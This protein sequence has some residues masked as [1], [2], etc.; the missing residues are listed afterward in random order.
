MLDVADLVGAGRTTDRAFN[1]V[2][3]DATSN[4]TGALFEAK[5]GEISHP[6]P[7]LV[8]ASG[9]AHKEGSRPRDA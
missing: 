8:P 1:V 7:Y 9:K 5:G 2:V 6:G 4:V 3:L